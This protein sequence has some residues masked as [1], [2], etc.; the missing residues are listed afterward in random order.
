MPIFNLR[1]MAIDAFW[2]IPMYFEFTT[3]DD[4]TMSNGKLFYHSLQEILLEL[5]DLFAFKTPQMAIDMPIAMV[6]VFEIDLFGES[7]IYQ[8]GKG[9]INRC[10]G[11]TFLEA[12]FGFHDISIFAIENLCQ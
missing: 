5:Y 2:A 8:D 1:S 9:S 11:D 12:L 3:L 4:K 6:A 7:A 10:L